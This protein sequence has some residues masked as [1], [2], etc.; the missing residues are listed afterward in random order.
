MKFIITLFVLI[1]T[2]LNVGE[3]QNINGRVT[4]S[5]YAFE[6]A[7][8]E[9]ISNKFLR[10][11]QNLL[12]NVNYDKFSLRTSLSLENDLMKKFDSDPRLRFFSLYVEGRNIA[13]LFSFKLGRQTLFHSIASGS[14][15]GLMLNVNKE[16]FKVSGYF[17]GNVPAYN[18]LELTDQ[19]GKDFIAGAKL[20]L[21]P[22]KGLNVGIGYV[23]KDFKPEE[24]SALRL[25]EEN[26]PYQVI[27][28][29]GS[30]QFKFLTAEAGY[31][32][33]K[34]FSSD[35]KFDYDL[36]Y[37]RTHKVEF[38]GSYFQIENL[39][40]NFYYNFREPLIRYNSYFT[41]FN[42][43]ENSSEIELGADYKLNKYFSFSGRYGNVNYSDEN[44]QRITLGVFSRFASVSYRK[45]LGYAGE[46][47]GLALS[48]AYTFLDG[49]IT[50][51][52]ALNYSSYKVSTTSPKNEL[53]AVS[54]GFNVRP[55]RIFSLDLQ[56]Q[57]VNNKIYKND[58]RLF[59]KVNYWFNTNLDVL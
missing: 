42:N 46:L 22:L 31:T 45:N 21:F 1:V 53:M 50:P 26:N 4:S 9:S 55:W 34:Y 12:L 18:K 36:N 11:Y 33:E 41:I 6:R 14:F 37:A 27:V 29:R 51:S 5:Y 10:S 32:F 40:V 2:L 47:D 23:Q 49:L 43:I 13:D 52:L 54:A 3:A 7:E 17:G 35:L 39:A 15:D 20:N 16:Y 8:S 19:F 30:S 56:G 38:F 25:D 28:S 44:S 48:S 58:Y 59:M 24:Y 57:Y